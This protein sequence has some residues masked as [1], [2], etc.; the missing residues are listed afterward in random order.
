MT[1][2]LYCVSCGHVRTMDTAR[3]YHSQ[4]VTPAPLTCFWC[5]GALFTT[6][7][8]NAPRYAPP[9]VLTTFDRQFL[10][11]WGIGVRTAVEVRR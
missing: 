11:A 1:R 7:Q 9:W 10:K 4:G 8:G 6:E 5:A 3:P 2:T